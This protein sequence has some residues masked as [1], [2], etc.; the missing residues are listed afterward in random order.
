MKRISIYAIAQE[1]G[2]STATVSKIVNNQGNIS[3]DTALRVL[4]IIKKHNYVPQQ[5]KQT[6]N[7][8]GV[9]TFNTNARPF[10]SPFNSRLLTGVCLQC[11]KE[12]KDMVLIDGDRLE[13]Y[14]PEELY[15]YYVNNSLAGVLL[16]NKDENDPFCIRMKQSGVPFLLLANST[17]ES[18]VNFVAARNYE[19]VS[20][21]VDYMICLGHTRIAYVGLQ[22]QKQESY[23]ERIRAFFDVHKKYGIEPR[24]DYVLA[25]PNAEIQTI[26]NALQKLLSRPEPPTALFVGSEDCMKIYSILAEMKIKVPEDISVAS[27]RLETDTDAFGIDYSSI[28]QPAA[29]I[30]RHGVT[31]LLELVN[32]SSEAV[33]EKL[34]NTVNF[35]ETIRRISEK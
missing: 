35:G 25:L 6:S 5:R 7:G 20:E 16:C 4:D 21:M 3:R 22:S 26:K 10:S 28:I 15:C 2:V 33:R 27:Y 29:R 17:I 23:Q 1:A 30:G 11:F 8:I 31:G 18:D 34:D 12:A 13:N 9:I 32:S 14:S 19:S 24:E